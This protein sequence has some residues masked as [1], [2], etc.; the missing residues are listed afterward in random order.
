LAVASKLAGRIIDI[1]QVLTGLAVLV[2]I[3][4]V[5]LELRQTRAIS[6]AQLTSDGYGQ[7]MQLAMA[8][9][10]EAPHETHAIACTQPE[11]LTDGDY[12]VL[13]SYYLVLLQQATRAY[14]ISIRTGFYSET[15]KGIAEGSIS[16]ILETVPGRIWWRKFKSELPPAFQ[17]IGSQILESGE[18]SDLVCDMD[19]WQSE[20]LEQLKK[21]DLHDQ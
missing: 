17:E 20:V 21:T 10:G 8:N 19:D 7:A 6:I 2:G 14:I 15:W 9:L 12:Q 11:K 1:V 16:D 13:N 5:V 18:S 4:L 3:V